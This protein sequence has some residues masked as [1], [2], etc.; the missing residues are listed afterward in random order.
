MKNINANINEKYYFKNLE[1]TLLNATG[2]F[3]RIYYSLTLRKDGEKDSTSKFIPLFL[4]KHSYDFMML[5]LY[6]F[7]SKARIGII[8]PNNFK[9]DYIKTKNNLDKDSPLKEI[10]D[11]C[12]LI[13]LE[14]LTENNDKELYIS[15]FNLIK[16]LSKIDMIIINPVELKHL[17]DEQINCM[18]GNG[19]INYIDID[20]N[21]KE[22]NG[23]KLLSLAFSH[24]ENCILDKYMKLNWEIYYPYM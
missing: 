17:T 1:G 24:K 15:N 19:K 8:C 10:L 5:L 4:G 14:D 2:V 9:E 7:S 6:I 21:V 23:N 16:I 13:I 20:G 3:Q 22:F 12:N 11:N 18:I